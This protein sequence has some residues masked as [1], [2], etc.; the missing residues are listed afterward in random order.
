MLLLAA[1]AEAFGAVF[2]ACACALCCCESS[3]LWSPA[4]SVVIVVVRERC[5]ENT[6]LQVAALVWQTSRGYGA[7][8]VPVSQSGDGSGE[9]A[10]SM[11]LP[12]PLLRLPRRWEDLSLM[13]LMPT[14]V[15][16]PRGGEIGK[17]ADTD[18]ATG[19]IRIFARHQEWADLI[20]SDP[21]G[22]SDD[23]LVFYEAVTHEAAHR[24]QL[25]STGFAYDLSRQ[26]FYAVA[27]AARGLRRP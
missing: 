21:A 15:L 25:V 7:A 19:A 3:G 26:W 17:V 9:S 10:P 13:S 2:T 18:W 6:T 23:E 20:S 27:A 4:R 12:P 8:L 16:F 5:P 22:F 14:D 11:A 24:L 1:A